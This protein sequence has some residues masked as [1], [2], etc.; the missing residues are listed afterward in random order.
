MPRRPNPNKPPTLLRI[1][2]IPLPLMMRLHAAAKQRY[3]PAVGHIVH[4]ATL[5]KRILHSL[6]V[7]PSNVADEITQRCRPGYLDHGFTCESYWRAGRSYCK[8]AMHCPLD[9]AEGIKSKALA[10]DMTQS[11]LVRQCLA[12]TLPPLEWEREQAE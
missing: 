5:A 7:T 8:L 6:C 12:E 1:I 2:E 10:E 11:Q 3:D 4:P 9:L